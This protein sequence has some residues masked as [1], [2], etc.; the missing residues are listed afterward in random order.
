MLAIQL[1][2]YLESVPDEAN[3]LVYVQKT[4]EVRQLL[5][6]D[7]DRNHNGHVV[8]DAEYDVPPKLTT[9]EREI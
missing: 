8:I 3:I 2:N 4:N 1:K 6:S 5:F 7:L 9:I